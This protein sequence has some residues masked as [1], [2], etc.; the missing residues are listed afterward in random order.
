MIHSW[1]DIRQ[2]SSQ[3]CVHWKRGM[4]RRLM[5]TNMQFT[6]HNIKSKIEHRPHFHKVTTTVLML[7]FDRQSAGLLA[8]NMYTC[9][10][11][12]SFIS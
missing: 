10:Q 6:I 2:E 8:H 9:S 1:K 3:V 12:N 11:I 5:A 7:A 4:K